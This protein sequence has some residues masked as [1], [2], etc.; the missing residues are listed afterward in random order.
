[1]LLK[2]KFSKLKKI[3]PNYNNI[4]KTKNNII[5][6]DFSNNNLKI[7]ADGNYSFDKK[8][9]KFNFELSKNKKEISFNTEVEFKTEP[10]ILKDINYKKEKDILSK[11]KFKGK[12]FDNKK[13]KFHNINFTENLNNFLLSNLYLSNK[14]KIIDLDK[15]Q[16]KFFNKNEK[17]NHLTVLKKMIYLN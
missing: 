5:N 7:V 8:F 17:L 15:L 2:Y 6:I 13:I 4:I 3:F 9:D 12:Y 14:F 16:I 10:I 11:I 1:L